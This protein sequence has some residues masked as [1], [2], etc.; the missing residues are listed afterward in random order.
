VLDVHPYEGCRVYTLAGASPVNAGSLRRL[1]APF[2]SIERSA[3]VFRPTLVHARTW[4]RACRTLLAEDLPAGAL[5]SARRARIDILPHQLEPA[6]AVVRG[7]GLRVLLADEVGLG[8]TIEAAL[9]VA[10]LMGRGAVER[11]LILTPPGLRDQWTSELQRFDL[12]AAVMDAAGARRLAATLPIGVN[13][14]TAAPLVIASIDFVKRPEVLPLLTAARWDIVVVDEAHHAAADSDRRSASEALTSQALCVLLLT[15]TPHTGDRHAFQALCA[16][17]EHRGDRLLVFRRSRQDVRLR[18]ERRLHR[19]NIRQ[20]GDEQRMLRLLRGFRRVVQHELGDH[21]AL[22]LSVLHKR[23]CS[24]AY[25]F[26]RT[27]A[28][29][30]D[31]LSSGSTQDVPQLTLPIPDS[32]GQLSPDDEAPMWPEEA[33]LPDQ[34]RERTLLTA[35]YDAALVAARQESKISALRRVLRRIGEPAIVFT[36]YRDTLTHLAAVLNETVFPL[37]LLHGGL[38]RTERR[39]AIEKFSR[40]THRVMLATDAGSEGLNLH[41][42]CRVVINL[43]LPWSPARLEQRIGRVDR[44]GQQRAVHVFH[45]I[46]GGAGERVV[47]DRL[48]SRVAAAQA[49]IAT[50]D[51]LGFAEEAAE[52]SLHTS[53]D[54]RPEARQEAERL[55]LC[56]RL[57]LAKEESLA[58]ID[59]RSP[60]ILVSRRRQTRRVVRGRLLLLWRISCEDAEGRPIAANVAGLALCRSIEAARLPAALH[61]IDRQ[62]RPLIE[63]VAALE[64]R[65]HAGVHRAFVT[66]LV[67]RQRFIAAPTDGLSRGFQ[68]G[69]FDRRNE[70]ARDQLESAAAEIRAFHRSRLEMFERSAQ[71]DAVVPRLVLVLGA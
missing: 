43:E 10:E 59:S 30:L 1:I 37:A 50:P 40:G 48:R 2:D 57:A 24:G 58:Q 36:E 23:A 67:D 53:L 56:R 25:A 62:C 52:P 69:L 16:L 42:A 34:R 45:L 55:A 5:L 49:D 60:A 12:K 3:P 61:E 65:R 31:T 63:S 68:P 18:V 28:R 71:V 15:A 20:T 35:L 22:A 4:R 66:A 33:A 32:S 26:A 27:I 7:L 38:T 41:E 46:A 47:L 70:H 13:P 14:W 21:A 11:V 51:P 29:R 17:G 6:L 19:L 39:V 9:I 64:A 8:K 44:I 54:L